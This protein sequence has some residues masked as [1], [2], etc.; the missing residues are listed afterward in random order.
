MEDQPIKFVFCRSHWLRF[1]LLS[2]ENSQDF[3]QI[4][5]VGASN[6]FEGL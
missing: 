5:S 4:L 3:S 1:H 6:V 2:T